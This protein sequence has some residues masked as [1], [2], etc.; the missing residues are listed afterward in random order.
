LTFSSPE[1][2]W[3]ATADGRNLRLLTNLWAGVGAHISPD[4]RRVAFH[5]VDELYAPLYVVDLDANGIVTA[6]RRVAQ[7]QSFA[8]TGASWSADG[9]HLYTTAVKTPPR[10]MRVRV[11]DGEPEDL[12]DGAMPTVAPDGRR[13]FYKKALGVSPLYARS[14]DGDIV[15]N[16]E[17][18]L[19]PD[20]VT[21]WG[22]FPTVR[23][24]YYVACDDR[25]D[26]VQ[27]RYFEFASR[28]SFDL[29]GTPL[30]GQPILTVSVDGRRLVYS[31]VPP[32]NGQLT[33]VTFRVA[34]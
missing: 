21:L 16:P 13:V 6:T 25:S 2:L 9:R 29:G 4:S 28:Q 14:L 32:D 22:I 17:E 5:K 30:R 33:R 23:G 34:R 1:G 3:I 26:P 18:Q 10:V 15:G 20:C 11:S 24:V 8:F 7:T 19:V 27:L 12:F 31:T